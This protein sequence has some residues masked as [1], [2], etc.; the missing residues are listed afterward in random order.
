MRLKGCVASE[1]SPLGRI[2]AYIRVSSKSQDYATQRHAIERAAQQRGESVDFWFEEKKSGR[3]LDRPE[4]RALLQRVRR[5][6][7]GKLY[8]FRLDRL[9]RSGIRDTLEVL[10]V[11][12][13]NGC[14]LKTVADEI[15]FDGP[16]ADIIVAALAY[17]AKLQRIQINENVA[18]ARR[19]VEEN[20]GAWG[21][22]RRV[23]GERV[24]RILLM[25]MREKK[26]IRQIASA[27]K[28][29]RSTVADVLAKRGAYAVK[30]GGEGG[31]D[32]RRT[33]N[34]SD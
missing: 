30:K 6:E 14:Q 33:R 7:I 13:T 32:D 2:A 26:S 9:S 8:T 15:D 34:R 3:S 25:R 23:D 28:V 31:D 5:A 11:L 29:P 20:G 17:S 27:L 22:P 1:A 24:E 10:E 21:R 16:A 18:A 4:L 19:R 12:K